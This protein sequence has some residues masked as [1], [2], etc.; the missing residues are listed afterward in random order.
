[1]S[2]ILN[3]ESINDLSQKNEEKMHNYV[4]DNQGDGWKRLMGTMVNSLLCVQTL[5]NREYRT[6]SSIPPPPMVGQRE[7]YTRGWGL[8]RKSDTL[9]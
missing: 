1:M 9:R 4:E 7:G 6:R 8:T 2:D 5:A 3:T